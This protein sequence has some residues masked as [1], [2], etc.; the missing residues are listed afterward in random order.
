MYVGIDFGTSRSGFGSYYGPPDG[1]SPALEML[2]INVR[3]PA[4]LRPY[5]KTLTA[6]LYKRGSWTV[7][8]WGW[9]ALERYSKLKLIEQ[10][11]YLFLDRFK[12]LL[13]PPGTAHGVELPPALTADRVISDYL[14]CLKDY[15]LKEIN[16]GSEVH[17]SSSSIQWALTVPANWT[18]AAKA[19]MRSAAATAGA[20]F[21]Q[22]SLLPFHLLSFTII[23]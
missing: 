22:R 12:L 3:Y 15:A 13:A 9:E 20:Y 14:R 23:Y 10:P 2:R 7:E 16:L 21:V 6:L 4:A 17:H 8:A 5:C 11:E 18:D 19:T 1:P